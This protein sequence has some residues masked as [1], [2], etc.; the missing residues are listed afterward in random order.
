MRA[1]CR[2]RISDT[3]R[4]GCFMAAGKYFSA[5]DDSPSMSLAPSTKGG[6]VSSDSQ[7][8]RRLKVSAA[9][10]AATSGGTSAGETSAADLVS[11]TSSAGFGPFAVSEY[12]SSIVVA[13]SFQVHLQIVEHSPPQTRDWLR[14]SGH[15]FKKS[16][17]VCVARHSALRAP[18]LELSTPRCRVSF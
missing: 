14:P 10:S 9:A 16:A 13:P 17:D 2:S 18:Q 6:R 4:Y 7:Y 5:T 11:S 15:S 8:M 12:R 3:G 1:S